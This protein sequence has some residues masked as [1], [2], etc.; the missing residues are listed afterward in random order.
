MEQEVQVRVQAQSYGCDPVELDCRVT[1]FDATARR[2]RALKMAALLVGGGVLIF[3]IPGAHIVG[4][5]CLI[6]AVPLGLRRLR[7]ELQVE[8]I[9]GTCPACG[10]LQTFRLPSTGKLPGT[11]SCPG[12]RAFL[13]LGEVR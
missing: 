1:R 2:R 7:Q 5:G 11:T 6:A 3:P 9:A 10:S 4:V 12:C 8:E 13:N